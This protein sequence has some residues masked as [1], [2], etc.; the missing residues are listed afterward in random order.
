MGMP[1]L[2]V[3]AVLVEGRSKSEVARQYGVSRRWVI[4][5]VQRY[6]AEGDAGLA[7]RSRRPLTSPHQTATAVEDEIIKIRKELDRAGHEAGAATIAFH[8]AQRDGRSPAVSTIWRVLSARGFVTPQPHK[9]PKSSYVRFVA[10]QPNERWQADITHWVLADGTDVEIFNLLDDHSRCC[11]DSHARQVFKSADVDLRFRETADTY[12]NPADL[13]TDNG[14]V[15]TG[16]SRGRGRVALEVT[17]HARGISFRHS[18][19]YHPQTCGKVERYHQTLKKWLTRQ[20]PARSIRQ[21]QAQLDTFRNYYNQVRPHRALHRHTPASAYTAPAQGPTDR[22]PGPWTIPGFVPPLL[23]GKDGAM[24]RSSKW[25]QETKAKAIRLVRD[26]VGDYGS[27]WAAIT[28]VAGRLG[29][30]AESLRKWIRQA[31][32]DTGQASGVS[33]ES[34]REIRELRRKNAELERTVEILKA[35]TG[36]FV[37]ECD[38]LR[39]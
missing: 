21:L 11:L 13:L 16:R 27:E 7:P 36:F 18:R 29:V 31:E 4:T 10:E 33:T 2:V 25:D 17:C 38:P 22:H 39:R 15:F 26:H 5:L 32:I 35:A 34:A 1:Q 30:S 24:P 37:R 19:P 8:L 3:T 12:G 9:R 14:A 23:V 28:T 6:F 20:P